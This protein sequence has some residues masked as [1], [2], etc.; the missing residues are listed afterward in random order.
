MSKRGEMRLKSIPL[1]LPTQERVPNMAG[2]RP[3]IGRRRRENG[4]IEVDLESRGASSNG[5]D[6]KTKSNRSTDLR[7]IILL[8]VLYTLQGIPMGLSASIPFLLLEK[9]NDEDC[10]WGV[11]MRS[12]P[13]PRICHRD[14]VKL[15][16]LSIFFGQVTLPT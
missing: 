5:G 6:A 8:L 9:V 10:G 4:A 13:F 12:S 15:Y 3:D 14:R 7:S 2:L 16:R 11:S 1:V